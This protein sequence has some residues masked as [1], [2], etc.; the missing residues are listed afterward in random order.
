MTSTHHSP[1]S[2]EKKKQNTSIGNYK[3]PLSMYHCIKNKKLISLTDI[4]TMVINIP[5][6]PVK[7]KYGDDYIKIYVIHSLINAPMN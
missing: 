4:Y 2:N 6:I 5:F 3:G 1:L 7:I